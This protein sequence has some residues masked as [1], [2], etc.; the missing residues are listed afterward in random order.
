MRCFNRA[1]RCCVLNV[2]V[3]V[4]STLSFFSSSWSVT[5][6]VST[7]NVVKTI[8]NLYFYLILLSLSL[9][10]FKQ[11]TATSSHSVFDRHVVNK[12]KESFNSKVNVNSYFQKYDDFKHSTLTFINSKRLATSAVVREALVF[13]R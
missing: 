5:V 10:N 9:L 4:L 12:C 2:Y 3:L 13:K 8:L 6:S 7:S 1:Y 11:K